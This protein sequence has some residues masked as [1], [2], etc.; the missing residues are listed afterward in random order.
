MSKA[1]SSPWTTVGGCIPVEFEDETDVFCVYS[2]RAFADGRGI[3]ILTTAERAEYLARL[4]AFTE[5]G[6][7]SGINSDPSPPFEEMELPGRGRGLI[8]N[9]TLYPGDRIFAY[10]PVLLLDEEAFQSMSEEESK[11]LQRMAVDALP[12]RAREMFWELLNWPGDDPVG[13]R[14]N[15]NAFGVELGDDFEGYAVFPEIAV[16]VTPSH[17]IEFNRGSEQPASNRTQRLNH[18]CRPNAAYYMDPVTLVQYVYVVETITPG[19]EITITYTDALLP[20]RKRRLTLSTFWGFNCS[21]SLCSMHPSLTDASDARLEQLSELETA[22]R[23]SSDAAQ[24]LISLY[25]QER[26]HGH[27]VDAYQVAAEAACAEGNRWRT[28]QHAHSAMQVGLLHYGSNDEHV[29]QMKRLTKH[30]EKESCWL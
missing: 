17:G 7:H 12:P 29:L 30:P 15:T 11:S 6:V 4:P 16:S 25:K 8:A 26:L 28:I 20:R 23:L 5:A 27:I 19:A 3:S 1:Q 22:D 9:K 14:I 2:S 10:T 18:D 21:C 24:A 13:D